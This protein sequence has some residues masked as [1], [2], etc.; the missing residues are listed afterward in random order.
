MRSRRTIPTL[1]LLALLMACEGEPPK[2]P[3]TAVVGGGATPTTEAPAEPDESAQAGP[4]KPDAAAG[5]A[6]AMACGCC[7]C[8]MGDGGVA[9]GGA[10]M[11]ANAPVVP[12]PATSFTVQGSLTMAGKALPFGVVY[13]EDAPVDPNAT[14]TA[15]ID[16][17]QMAFVPFV[18]V[19]PAGGKVTFHNSDPFPHNVFSPD[20]EKFNMGTIS[21]NQTLVHS[22]AKAGEYSLLCNLHPGMLGYLVVAPSSY[23][24]KTDAKGHYA[25][26]GVPPGAYKITAWSPRLPTETKSVDVKGGDATLDFE[27]HR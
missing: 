6:P 18:S 24:A 22:F 19:I 11:A 1:A 9:E 7:P 20:A 3:A 5:A 2:T 15:R 10:A 8:A 27:L 23:F 14:M 17:R 4:A 12:S 25:M 13:L 16:N 26:K 21:Q